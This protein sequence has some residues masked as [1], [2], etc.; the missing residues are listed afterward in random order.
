MAGDAADIQMLRSYYT[1]GQAFFRSSEASNLHS[2]YTW[3]R[4]IRGD[5]RY[6]ARKPPRNPACSN[7]QSFLMVWVPMLC[8]ATTS[9]TWHCF[10]TVTSNLLSPLKKRLRTQVSWFSRFSNWFLTSELQYI[11]SPS[12]LLLPDIKGCWWQKVVGHS[13][14]FC[15]RINCLCVSWLN[16]RLILASLPTIDW[17]YFYSR[18]AVKATSQSPFIKK[19]TLSFHPPKFFNFF[20]KSFLI[21]KPT[22]EDFWNL[23]RTDTFFSPKPFWDY[24]YLKR[25]MTR[26]FSKRPLATLPEHTLY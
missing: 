21:W 5:I 3:R 8:L 17:S 2:Y 11:L 14:G 13:D 10:W 1:E 24:L 12:T 25:T 20:D 26:Y 23:S 18:H 7:R 9:H 16:V 4:T 19:L 15:G 22:I 6:C